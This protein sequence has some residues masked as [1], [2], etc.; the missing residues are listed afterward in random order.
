VP[1]NTVLSLTPSQAISSDS[2]ALG[3]QYYFQLV[4]SVQ[5]PDGNTIPKDS[6]TR[7][8]VVELDEAKHDYTLQF[9][10]L[11]SAQTGQRYALI[12][13]SIIHLLP[14]SKLAVLGNQPEKENKSLLITGSRLEVV[15]QRLPEALSV[16]PTMSP[17]APGQ[18]PNTLP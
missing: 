15:T 4:A 12:A 13:Q 2:I 9:D 8:T 10:A 18:L 1:A 7:A 5:L 6:S 14:R 11:T 16:P 3:S 17:L